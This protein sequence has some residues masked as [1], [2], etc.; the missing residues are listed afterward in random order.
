MPP[1]HTP[2]STNRSHVERLYPTSLPSPSPEFLHQIERTKSRRPIKYQPSYVCFAVC[3]PIMGPDK[4][5]YVV[6]APGQ[7]PRRCLAAFKHLYFQ[8]VTC[9]HLRPGSDFRT[10]CGGSLCSLFAHRQTDGRMDS[11][12]QLRIDAGLCIS[13][14]DD[15]RDKT[16][17]IQRT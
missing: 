14:R 17:E 16:Q 11:G 12:S 13:S 6:N 9:I 8:E 3:Y 7:E 1:E 15:A 5:I 10:A 2:L 4:P